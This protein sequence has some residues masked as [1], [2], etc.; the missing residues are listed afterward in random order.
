[1][2]EVWRSSVADFAKTQTRETVR[3]PSERSGQITLPEASNTEIDSEMP[4]PEEADV[5]DR[6]QVGNQASPRGVHRIS[7]PQNTAKAPG[8]REEP[9]PSQNQARNLDFFERPSIGV[10]DCFQNDMLQGILQAAGD[11]GQ[12]LFLLTLGRFLLLLA[13]LYG[14]AAFGVALVRHAGFSIALSLL[15]TGSVAVLAAVAA[16]YI[17]IRKW[18]TGGDETTKKTCGAIQTNIMRAAIEEIARENGSSGIPPAV[19][20][21]IESL[22]A[23]GSHPSMIPVQS[24]STHLTLSHTVCISCRRRVT[25]PMESENDVPPSNARAPSSE[26]GPSQLTS[27]SIVKWDHCP[28]CDIRCGRSEA[29]DWKVL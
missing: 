17:S 2:N 15:C 5:S 10:C 8:S 20:N 28:Q 1:M 25:Q 12:R 18:N 19:K 9:Q 23:Q 26:I 27:T 24:D 4:C 7:I 22:V 11:V 3:R 13:F 16:F 21:L 29:D 6:H 14:T